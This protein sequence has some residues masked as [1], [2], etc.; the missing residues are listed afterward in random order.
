[1]YE[2]I[3]SDLAL[4]S[5]DKLSSK[6]RTRIV[7][8]ISS[9]KKNPFRYFLRLKKMKSYR[10][11]VGDYRVIADISYNQIYIHYVIHRRNAYKR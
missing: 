11:R 1:M 2:V 5:L 7:N 9:T 6:I 3:Y 10:L 8:K 4:E